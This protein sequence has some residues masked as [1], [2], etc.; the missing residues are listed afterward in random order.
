[1][2]V[3]K[4]QD[5]L[6]KSNPAPIIELSKAN[7]ENLL[8]AGLDMN[9]VF[10]LQAFENGEDI[11]IELDNL[12]VLGWR[13]TLLRKGYIT[14]KKTISLSGKEL[15]RVLREGGV[16]QATKKEKLKE[17]DSF[18]KWWKT[19][20][21][22]DN[23]SVRGRTFQGSRS[24]KT[25]KDECLV[26]FEKILNEGE[27]TAQEMIDALELEVQQKKEMSLTEGKNKLSYMH[28]SLTYLNQR[29]FDNYIELLRDKKALQSKI[30]IKNSIDI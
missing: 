24:L 23:F 14:E 20:P 11:A 28:N 7:L 18:E 9:H 27:Y 30:E 2:E 1:M 15:L 26:K 19:F 22:T 13:Q 5:S 8:A 12:K 17:N 6:E 21:G 10:L 3:L 4:D 29:D 25:K 16:I